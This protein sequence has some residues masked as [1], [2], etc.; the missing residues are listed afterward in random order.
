MVQ[1][2]VDKTLLE[3]LLKATRY[4]SSFKDEICKQLDPSSPTPLQ[5]TMAGSCCLPGWFE[6]FI[7]AAPNQNVHTASWKGEQRDGCVPRHGS[8][9]MK[10]KLDTKTKMD[11]PPRGMAY[12][13]QPPPS[14]RLSNGWTDGRPA[15]KGSCSGRPSLVQPNGRSGGVVRCLQSC[16]APHR[17]LTF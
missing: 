7:P 1:C 11:R 13:Q 5:P 6:I 8:H 10:A 12:H 3:H 9:L 14:Y 15:R 2:G 16:N 4:L 17:H